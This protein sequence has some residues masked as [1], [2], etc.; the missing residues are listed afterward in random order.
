MKQLRADLVRFDPWPLGTIVDY[1]YD[2][3][4]AEMVKPAPCPPPHGSTKA[5]TLCEGAQRV[6][7]LAAGIVTGDSMRKHLAEVG[8]LNLAISV[9]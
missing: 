9:A 8:R 2:P 1:R 5:L 6:G 3:K 4:S 7:S